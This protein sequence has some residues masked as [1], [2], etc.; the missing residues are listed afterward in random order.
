MWEFMKAYSD[1]FWKAGEY[2]WEVFQVIM[3]WAITLGFA[4]IVFVTI[5]IVAGYIKEEIE[6]R[7]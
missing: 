4:Y 2:A 5:Q 3:A 6:E 1:S 7:K